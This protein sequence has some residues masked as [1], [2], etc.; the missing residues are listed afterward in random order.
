MK[1][2]DSVSASRKSPIGQR[3][4]LGF[5]RRE[6]TK[7][8][9]IRI[10]I[11]W[12]RVAIAAVALFLMAF[13]AKSV[14][15]YYFFKEVRDFEDVSFME[16]IPYPLNRGAVRVQQG[17][18]QVDQGIEA[19]EREEYRRA[20]SLLREGVSR[21]PGNIEGR[22]ILAQLY[23]GWR[24]D[25]AGDL[26]LEGME[27]GKKDSEY[28]RLLTGILLQEKRDKELIDLPEKVDMESLSEEAARTVA[29]GR[30]QAAVNNG[31]FDVARQIYESTELRSTL[32]GVLLG[33]DLY[34]RTNRAE[35]A[36]DVLLSVINAAPEGNLNPI[37]N[38]LIQ[39]YQE[40][41]L[42]ERAR[43]VALELTIR[44]A[45]EWE[46][47]LRLID[48]LSDAGS[49]ERRD[50]EIQ[51]MLRDHRN[52]EEAMNALARISAQYGNVDAAARL[53]ELALEKGYDLSLFSLTLAEAMVM[54]EQFDRAI[55][56][57]NE[58]AEEDPAWLLNAQ[59][60]FNSIRSLA[61][62]GAGDRE[63]GNLYL[64]NFLNSR[65]S[66]VN[67]LFQS[68]KIFRRFDL[69]EQAFSLLEEAYLRN[70]RNE[71]VLANLIDV[72]MELGAFFSVRDHLQALFELRRPDYALLED[73][74]QRLRSDR[75]LF[76]QQ[77]RDLLD[78]LQTVIAEQNNMDWEI[79]E[80]RQPEDS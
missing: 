18:Y 71:A 35:K 39:V 26:L 80:A 17:D 61:Y 33:V 69:T 58:L 70:A 55:A 4:W 8:G 28:M 74:Q 15:L 23:A 3:A 13:M 79:W 22:K 6:Q 44:N 66:N 5:A 7:R 38:K 73:I 56:L 34:L 20:F 72:E 51:A 37:Y 64:R 62:F 59:S 40:R 50:R 1:G 19:L 9:S 60:T 46:P 52:N 75:F 68:S 14:G 16:M 67:M 31:R 45:M 32:E 41:D 49:T 10:H 30:L 12:S 27:H 78:D 21:S 2:S 57:C 24:G 11:L 25:L 63:L 42:H 36:T 54:D 65:Q 47:R 77:R 53:Y 43:E 76:T 29:V 48:V